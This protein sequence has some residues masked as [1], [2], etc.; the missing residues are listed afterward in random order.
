MLTQPKAAMELVQVITQ[1]FGTNNLMLEVKTEYK[2]VLNFIQ[3]AINKDF[4]SNETKKL[5]LEPSKFTGSI[6]LRKFSKE[7]RWSHKIC[8]AV[9]KTARLLLRQLGCT[10]NRKWWT[11]SNIEYLRTNFWL[12]LKK[13]NHSFSKSTNR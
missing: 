4:V 11:G 12:T 3:K 6:P 7:Q 9:K 5:N 1:K 13:I 8:Y 2:K 10:P